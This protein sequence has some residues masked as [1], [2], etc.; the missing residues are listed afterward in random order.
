VILNTAAF[1]AF[2]TFVTGRKVVWIR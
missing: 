1:V 2:A